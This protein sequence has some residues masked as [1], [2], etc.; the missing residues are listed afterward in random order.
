M[1]VLEPNNNNNKKLL[2]PPLPLIAPKNATYGC[3]TLK[4]WHK[5]KRNK[6]H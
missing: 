2:L 4:V 6:H 5:N 3:W 1:K